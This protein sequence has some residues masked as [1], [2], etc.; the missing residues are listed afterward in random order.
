M[1]SPAQSKRRPRQSPNTAKYRVRIRDAILAAPAGETLTR[2]KLAE[3]CGLDASSPAFREVWTGRPE[4]DYE[5][6]EITLASLQKAYKH[7]QPSPE[8]TFAYLLCQM[9]VLQSA[10]RHSERMFGAR[11]GGRK[12]R[13]GEAIEL[14]F[15]VPTGWL[16]RYPEFKTFGLLPVSWTPR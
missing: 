2:A 11:S 10:D 6:L 9:W 7:R 5:F 14:R 13:G 3:M 16:T 4:Y 1:S 15:R 12:F 8:Q